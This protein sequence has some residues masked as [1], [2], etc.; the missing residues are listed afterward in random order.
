MLCNKKIASNPRM[1]TNITWSAGISDQVTAR[2]VKLEG[3]AK[4]QQHD[5]R[6]VR[7]TTY[8]EAVKTFP[9]RTCTLPPFFV[10]TGTQKAARPRNPKE[11]CNIRSTL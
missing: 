7:A 3:C 9:A 8:A 1:A 2:P 4:A 11:M 10:K 5:P 6:A